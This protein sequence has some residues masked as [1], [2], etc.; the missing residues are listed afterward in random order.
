MALLKKLKKLFGKDVV[1][2]FD[3]SLDIQSSMAP[4]LRQ[5]VMKHLQDSHSEV[6]TAWRESYQYQFDHPADYHDFIRRQSRDKTWGTDIE[7]A[8]LGELLGCHVSVST[9]AVDDSVTPVITTEHNPFY[10]YVAPNSDAP[11]IHLYNIGN[12]H[13]YVNENTKADGNCL[14][15]AV[16][17]GLQQAII[18]ESQKALEDDIKRTSGP[19]S[20]TAEG[21]SMVSLGNALDP[22]ITRQI[23]ADYKLALQLAREE[24]NDYLSEDTERSRPKK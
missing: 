24:M 4:I 6:A 21:D 1:Q 10:L 13:W 7:A 15:N 11:H 3:D 5:S 20:E 18:L 17:Q 12:T 19:R 23:I 8:A 22:D 9:V 16:A 14:Y 2:A